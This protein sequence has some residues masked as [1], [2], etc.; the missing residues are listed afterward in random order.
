MNM[1][2]LKIISKIFEMIQCSII[3]FKFSSGDVQP[4]F[5]TSDSGN[6]TAILGKPALLNCRVEHV[7][8]KT[9]SWIRHSDTHLLTAGR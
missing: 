3:F 9:V 7:G 4:S 2:I 8:N 1:N 6:V 5:I